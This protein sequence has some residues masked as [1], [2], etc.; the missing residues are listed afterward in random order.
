[1]ETSRPQIAQTVEIFEDARLVP[2]VA[3]CAELDATVVIG[4]KIPTDTT[5]A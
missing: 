5:P 2:R 4:A 1:V 3:R